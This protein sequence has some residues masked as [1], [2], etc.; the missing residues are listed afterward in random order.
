M[1]AIVNGCC[2]ALLVLSPAVNGADKIKVVGLFSNKAIVVVDGR[3]I[4][5][6]VNQPTPDG[7]T[8]ISAN[9]SEAVIEMNGERDTYRLGEHIGAHF[10]EPEAGKS[11]TIAPDAGG[12][13]EVNGSING[14]QVKFLVDTG[15][16]HVSMNRNV[17]KRI[18][19]DYRSAREGLSETASGINKVFVLEL[20][21]VTVG[22]IKLNNVGAS[23]HDGDH[24]RVILL[25]NTFLNRVDMVRE[26]SMLI[27]RERP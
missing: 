18:G 12:S 25:G 14:F 8:L 22:G 4:L 21:T 10:K 1:K 20:D 5:L 23:V 2:L 3:Q 19:L 16:T 24:P 13:Y 6:S 9:S 11:V 15:A 17:A 27:L 7:I 26:S